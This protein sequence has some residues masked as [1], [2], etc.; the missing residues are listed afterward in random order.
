[1]NNTAVFVRINNIRP[2]SNADRLKLVTIF[3]NQVIIGI[4]SKEGD[5]GIY[6]DA[7]LQLSEEFALKNDLIRRKNEDGTISGGMF[8]KNRKVRCQKFRG[9]RSDGFFIP[10]NS[11]SYIGD[12]VVEKDTII[13]NGKYKYKIGDEFNDLCDGRFKICNKFISESTR[14]LSIGKRKS[15]QK[16]KFD[17][18]MFKEHIDTLHL[19]KHLDHF[20]INERI[21]ITAKLH[22]TSHR[23]GHVLVEQP[24]ERWKTISENWLGRKIFSRKQKWQYLS[25]TRRVVLQ[26]TNNITQFHD[27]L[28]RELAVVPFINNLRKG[29]TVFFEIVGYEPN[30][31]PIMPSVNTS[32]LND[33]EFVQKYG[34]QIIF[35]YGCDIGK[36]DV[37]VYRIS[38]TNEDGDTYDYSWEDIKIR[39]SELGVKFVPEIYSG[40]IYDFVSKS[41]TLP[42]NIGSDEIKAKFIQLIDQYVSRPDIIDP[43]HI[44]EGVVIRIESG[45]DFMAYKHKSFEFKVLEDI[46]SLSN[47]INEEDLQ[48]ASIS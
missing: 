11:L 10:I 20:N 12:I 26:P 16:F 7:N 18:V 45:L 17:S 34:K 22:G 9:E 40:T 1:M 31:K 8:D 19:G 44:L 38:T 23:Y 32:K 4:E 21:V 15:R 3:G 48:E 13:I 33:K 30:G 2:H 39:C 5:V 27:P 6:F 36:H 41:Y 25:G 35:K 37:Y 46:L 47:T 43:S 24:L 28:L 29:E 14:S 42:K